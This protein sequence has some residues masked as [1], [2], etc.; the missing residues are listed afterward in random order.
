MED[1]IMEE[2]KPKREKMTDHIENLANHV[3]GYFKTYYRLTVVKLTEKVVNVASAFVNALAV[4]V[5]GF[6]FLVFSCIGIA[7][8]LGDVVN[9]TAGGFLLM[10]G[11]FGIVIAVLILMRKK[12]LFP[13]F[14]NMLIKKI[15]D[16]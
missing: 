5:F 6:L 8:W 13:L 11:I 10:A 1:I 2:V 15:Y 4:A 12:T 9:S 7:I 3:E 14:R 16:K